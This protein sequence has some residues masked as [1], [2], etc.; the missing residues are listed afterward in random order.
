MGYL[1]AKKTPKDSKKESKIASP[2]PSVVEKPEKPQ[3][4]EKPT[5]TDATK[6]PSMRIWTILIAAVIVVVIVAFILYSKYPIISSVPFSTFKSGLQGASRISITATYNNQSQLSNESA[7]FASIVQV[8]AHTRKASTIDFFII[9]KTTNVCTYSNSG[10]GGQVNPVTTNATFCLSKAYGEN[11]LF[12]NYS[13][14]NST[15]ITANR[16]YVYANNAY[17]AACPI[18]IELS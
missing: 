13:T 5:A 7:C 2:K 14:T 6:K 17:L 18:A 4:P 12:L 15:T 3:A 8:V 11:G 16:M 1:A 9:D 10:L